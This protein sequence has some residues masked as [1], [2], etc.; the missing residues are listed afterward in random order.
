[1]KQHKI[2][3][4][5]IALAC[6]LVTVQAQQGVAKLTASYNA[7]I[8]VGN[9]KE[10]ISG[11]SYRGFLV[12]VLYGVNDNLSVGLG[13]GFQDFYQKYPRQLYHL[14]DGSDMSAVLTY[15]IQI[16]PLLLQGKYLFTPDA[17]VQP[18]AALGVGGNLISFNE[19]YGEFGNAQTK[20]GFA[21]RPEAGI[22]VPFRKGGEAGFSLGASYNIMPFKNGDFQNLNHIGVHAGVS[23][24]MR[25]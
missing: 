18:Y 9:F 4:S 14:S 7:G 2:F 24:P 8:P 17:V 21:A 12:N 13:G 16:I 15:S 10:N 25:R 5:I 20:F 11:T 23:I 6:T 3:L 22:Y 1:M 19:L